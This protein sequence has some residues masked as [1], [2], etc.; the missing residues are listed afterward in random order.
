VLGISGV[1]LKELKQL[2]DKVSKTLS[3]YHYSRTASFLVEAISYI[4]LQFVLVFHAL[5]LV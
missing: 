4:L 2:E 3:H 5:S 1:I